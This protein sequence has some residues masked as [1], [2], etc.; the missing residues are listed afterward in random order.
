M[1]ILKKLLVS[2]FFA[3]AANSSAAQDSKITIADLTWTGANAI[4]H[5]IQAII[6]GP[7]RGEAEIVKASF[8]IGNKK[9]LI[10]FGTMFVAGILGML[11]IIGCGIGILFT[12]SI[13]YLPVFFIYKEVIGFGE[14][15][16]IEQIGT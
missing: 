7:M 13:I 4:G 14:T 15:S 12:I 16:E 3:I 2:L 10:T 11:G 9:W 5:V 1:K 6:T 8:K